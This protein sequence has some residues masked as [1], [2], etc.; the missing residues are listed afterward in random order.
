MPAQPYTAFLFDMDGTLIDNMPYHDRVWLEFLGELGARPDPRHFHE[1]ATG[2]TN[3]EILRLFLGA[4]LSDEAA[5]RYSIEKEIRY[6]KLYRAVIQPLPGLLHFLAQAHRAGVRLGLATSAG[7]EN[8]DFVIDLLGIAGFFQAVIGSEDVTHG[9]PDPQ[10]FLLAAERLGTD[11]AA[12]LVFEDS[13]NGILAAHRAGMRVVALLSG[14]SEQTA[15]AQPGVIRAA[16]DYTKM[17]D[18]IPA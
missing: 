10:A 13:T 16:A 9:K 6:R 18:L 1:Q 11:P 14:M 2:K 17:T 12:C 15:L 5:Q 7:H 8:I 3:R 4:D